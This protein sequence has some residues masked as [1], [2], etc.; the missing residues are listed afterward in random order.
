MNMRL[1]LRELRK[2]QGW[3]LEEA[4]SRLGIAKSH[5]SEVETGK[6]NLSAPMMDTAAKVF[7]VNVTQLY[8]AG[9]F[10]DDLAAIAEELEKMTPE[11]RQAAVRIVRSMRSP[12][13]PE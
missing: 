10:A 5:L 7:D 3:T 6:K 1:R 12:V 2:K 9:D 8:D 13:S 11:G 4:A